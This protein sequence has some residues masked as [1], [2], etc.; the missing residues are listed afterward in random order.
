[1]KGLVEQFN[2]GKASAGRKLSALGIDLG[3]TNSSA[4]VVEWGPGKEPACRVLDIDQPTRQGVFSGPIVPSVVALLPDRKI[5][6]GEGAKR[7]RAFLQDYGL[8]FEK[9]IFY[10]TKNEMGL[11]KTYFRAPGHLDHASKI[12]GRILSF[13]KDAAYTD[14]LP[15]SRESAATETGQEPSSAG[16]RSVPDAFP[17][18]LVSVTVPAS[19]RLNQRRDTLSSCAEAG[20]ALKADD[21]LEEPTAALIDYLANEGVEALLG[22][23]DSTLCLIFDFGGGTC[24]VSIVRIGRENESGFLAMSQVSCSR[25]HR[26]GGGDIDVAIVHEKLI[27]DLLRENN[28]HPLDL[29]WSQKKKG[30]EPQLIGKAEALKIAIC[31][32][33][34][35][36]R[37]F[38][39]SAVQDKNEIQASQPQVVCKLGR[40]EL[41]LSRPSITGA[42]FEKILAP[43]LDPDI[44]FGRETEYRLMQSIFAPL[45]DAL[46]RAGKEADEIDFVLLAGGS[47]LIPQVQDA[48]RGYFRNAELGMFKDHLG[49]QLAVARGAALNAA[50]LAATGRPFLQPILHDG[51]ALVTEDGKLNSLVSAKTPLPFPA[52]GSFL[53]ETL[54]LPKRVAGE[55]KMEI[56]GESDRQTIFEEIWKLPEGVKSGEK[57]CLEY[58]LTAGKQFEC[59]AFLSARPSAGIDILIENPLVNVFSPN[60]LR[61]NIEAAEEVLRKKKG[62]DDQ[63]VRTYINLAK[64][65]AELNQR[66]KAIDYLRTAQVKL[67]NPSAGILHLQAICFMELG[68]MERAEKLY[69]EAFKIDPESSAPMFSLALAYFEKGKYQE[70]VQILEEAAEKCDEDGPA[71]A[72]KG[73]CLMRLGNKEHGRLALSEAIKR[74]GPPTLLSDWELGSYLRTVKLLG[75]EA[76][77]KEAETLQEKRKKKAPEVSNED[78]PRPAIIDE[79]RTGKSVGNMVRQ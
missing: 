54:A 20:L 34:E 40:L 12:A 37:K 76:L 9:N 65:H 18:D 27:P 32:E 64:W 67:Q 36:L 73:D 66:E 23:R 46:Q 13:I 61:M 1:M 5:W 28:I 4:A 44:L 57:I 21:L 39:R 31:R 79:S 16:S 25:Y 15:A 48:V 75:E 58:R 63:D 22:D 69:R 38:G 74:F 35:K 60:T 68:N 24:D 14:A 62:G 6:V 50:V 8:V 77:I 29:T 53:K 43:F 11:R 10:D 52:D 41:L 3:T 56:V 30:L 45:K 42:E 47:S 51:L 33:I 59:R 49:M 7:L 19:F 17:Y 72:L 70:A 55:I 2:L 78:I 26:L 71:L